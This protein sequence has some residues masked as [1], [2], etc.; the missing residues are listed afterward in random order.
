MLD[1]KLIRTKLAEAEWN[2]APK[3]LEVRMR[4][5]NTA[6]EIIISNQTQV[7][8]I[9]KIVDASKGKLIGL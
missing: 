9:S 7:A 3:S 2:I 1:F 6:K 5:K 8:A 4:T